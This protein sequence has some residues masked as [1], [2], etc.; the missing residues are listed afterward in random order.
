MSDFIKSFEAMEESTKRFIGEFIVSSMIFAAVM[1]IILGFIFVPSEKF[2][3]QEKEIELKII[4]CQQD[5]TLC[6]DKHD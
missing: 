2:K 5:K 1:T 3:I 4:R 6:G